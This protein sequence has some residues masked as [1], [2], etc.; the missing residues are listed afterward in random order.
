MRHYNMQC[1]S[2]NLCTDAMYL[3]KS[4]RPTL[5][6]TDIHIPYSSNIN[7]ISKGGVMSYHGVK[8]IGQTAVCFDVNP[9]FDSLTFP[10]YHAWII[11]QPFVR[12][13][14]NG[15]GKENIYSRTSMARTP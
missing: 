15:T 5:L 13:R 3:G 1:V 4:F 14:Y 7:H 2:H 10:G 8:V 12:P 9:P 6:T 11:F